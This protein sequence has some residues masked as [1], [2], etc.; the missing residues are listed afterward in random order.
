[1]TESTGKLY[2]P[3]RQADLQAKGR[4]YGLL[5]AVA[6]GALFAGVF[7][8]LE[9][10]WWLSAGL[11]VAVTLI[12]GVTAWLVTWKP[13]PTVTCLKC[14]DY[15]WIDDIAESGGFYPN[16][17]NERYSYYRYMGKNAPIIVDDIAGVDLIQRRREIGM[18]WI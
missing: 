1:M 18:P 9:G 16:C 6:M 17:G 15:G 14:G 3:K 4:R 7:W 12:A 8:Y 11:F 10:I 2:N 5:G 13:S